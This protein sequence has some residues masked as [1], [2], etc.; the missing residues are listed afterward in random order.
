MVMLV[1]EPDAL[2]MQAVSPLLQYTFLHTSDACH[3]ATRAYTTRG[4]LRFAHHDQYPLTFCCYVECENLRLPSQ[5]ILCACF[6]FVI[7]PINLEDLANNV[8]Q[9]IPQI[10]QLHKEP[11][12]LDD[13]SQRLVWLLARKMPLEIYLES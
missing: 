8:Y 9:V 10:S 3:S 4:G 2:K 1:A 11:S 12:N 7:R 6:S 5:Q 13:Q